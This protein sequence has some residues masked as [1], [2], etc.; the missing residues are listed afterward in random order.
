MDSYDFIVEIVV[1]TYTYALQK[2]MNHELSS[3][4]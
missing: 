2:A 1:P 4:N 3:M